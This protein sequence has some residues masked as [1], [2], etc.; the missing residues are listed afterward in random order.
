MLDWVYVTV[1]GKASVRHMSRPMP[2]YPLYFVSRLSCT[3]LSYPKQGTVLEMMKTKKKNCL[4]LSIGRH[5]YVY[6]NTS[7]YYFIQN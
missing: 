5:A 1:K 3:K 2:R 6:D 7:F 4:V